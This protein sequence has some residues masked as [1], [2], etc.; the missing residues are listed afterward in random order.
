[1]WQEKSFGAKK[2]I[3]VP[4]QKLASVIIEEVAHQRL[5]KSTVLWITNQEVEKAK[6]KIADNVDSA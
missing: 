3:R 6:K 4:E 5:I 1:L 2:F